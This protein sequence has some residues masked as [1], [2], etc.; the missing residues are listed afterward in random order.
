MAPTLRPSDA[1]FS[2]RAAGYAR[3][4]ATSPSAWMASSPPT[5]PRSREGSPIPPA[6]ASTSGCDSSPE[7]SLECRSSVLHR[8]LH[9]F[10]AD[11][12]FRRPDLVVQAAEKA[13]AEE[14]VN[15]P[16]LW[17]IVRVNAEIADFVAEC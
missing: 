16:A 12:S 15:P 9:S 1:S 7:A 10:A 13:Q 3:G 8:L 17:Q 5:A 2:G 6:P 4:P 14:A 11:A